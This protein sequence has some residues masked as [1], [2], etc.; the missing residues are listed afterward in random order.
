MKK[1][2]MK[3][4]SLGL[5][6]ALGLVTIGGAAPKKAVAT[7]ETT[8]PSE[9]TFS[10]EEPQPDGGWIEAEDH[11][12]TDKIRQLV[13]DANMGILGVSHKPIAY[14]SYQIVAGT[15][16]CILCKRS[17]IIP[18][19]VYSYELMYIYEDLNGFCQITG[20][21]LVDIADFAK[22]VDPTELTELKLNKTE[23][24]IKK[25]KKKTL[26]PTVTY[27]TEE[28]PVFVWRSS[29]KKVAT[30][31]NGVITAKKKGTCIIS[32]MIKGLPETN[33]VCYV[34]VKK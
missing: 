31:K 13:S 30:V 21:K 8:A 11:T 9:S 14:I 34:K 4:A 16:H 1:K 32:C 20:I 10:P 17:A 27:G 26:K 5:T 28:S 2:A 15:N 12:V 25:G 6:L 19:P 22:Y 3:A 18:N 24:V 23:I 29:N 7:T 33:R